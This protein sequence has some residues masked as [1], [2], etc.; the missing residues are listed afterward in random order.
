MAGL[1]SAFSSEVDTGSREENAFKQK[2]LRG[3]LMAF[4]PLAQAGGIAA[5]A[6]LHPQAT[7][8]AGRSD[9]RVR[10]AFGLGS[11]PPVG[12]IMPQAPSSAPGTSSMPSRRSCS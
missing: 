8:V 1:G 10:A 9:L 3:G 5:G 4:R 2:E 11:E 7:A 6:A 12:T